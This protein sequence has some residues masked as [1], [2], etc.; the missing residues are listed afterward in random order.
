[1]TR[2]L[3]N[4]HSATQTNYEVLTSIFFFS[5]AKI[6]LPFALA[7]VPFCIT[8]R[9]YVYN[10][11]TIGFSTS[12]TR[13]LVLSDVFSKKLSI[14]PVPGTDLRQSN[15]W[16]GY[17]QPVYI[18]SMLETNFEDIQVGDIVQFKS[19]GVKSVGHVDSFD[20]VGNVVLIRLVRR[21]GQ[22]N[23]CYLDDSQPTLRV[24]IIECKPIDAFPSQRVAWSSASPHFNP[25]GNFF[26]AFEF[27][28]YRVSKLYIL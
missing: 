6:F 14:A 8:C 23:E 12:L 3:T 27:S 25:H 1:M 9:A 22:G 24:D 19:G 10:V 16:S 20:D 5:M 26:C 17:R 2:N 18:K 4:T 7:V 21:E 11:R 28:L 15:R 13:N